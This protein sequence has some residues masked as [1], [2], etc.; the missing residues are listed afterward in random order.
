MRWAGNVV[1]TGVKKRAYKFFVDMPEGKR[2]LE[3]SRYK[4]EVTVKKKGKAIHVT[5]RGR[6]GFHIF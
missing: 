5:N 4:W 6:R 1:C 2:P 3:R